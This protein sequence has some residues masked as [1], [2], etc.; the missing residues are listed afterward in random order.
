MSRLWPV[1][2]DGGVSVRNFNQTFRADGIR[3]KVKGNKL[4]LIHNDLSVKNHSDLWLLGLC[5]MIQT[6]GYKPVLTIHTLSH[7][8]SMDEE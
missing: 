3:Q 5:R 8:S 2:R 1:E 4:K 7:T 6:A